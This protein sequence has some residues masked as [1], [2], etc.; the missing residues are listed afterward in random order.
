MIS[1]STLIWISIRPLGRTWVYIV[2]SQKIGV[3]I[4]LFLF[5]FLTV[6]AGFGLTKAGFFPTEAARGAAQ[7]VLVRRLADGLASPWLITQCSSNSLER[8]DAMPFVLQDRSCVYP[9]KY[10][11]ASAPDHCGSALR[12]SRRGNGLGYQTTFLGAQ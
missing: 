1:A 3:Q 4:Y 8:S 5:S 9:E 6:G 7:M 11:I 2:L 10:W 12:N